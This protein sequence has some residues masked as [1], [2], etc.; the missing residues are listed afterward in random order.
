MSGKTT[1]TQTSGK[2][3][4]Q[5]SGKQTGTQTPT[6]KQA[7]TGSVQI[8]P[9]GPPL[10]GARPRNQVPGA[11]PA[12]ET[13][14]DPDRWDPSEQVTRAEIHERITFARNDWSVSTAT[15]LLDR[16]AANHRADPTRRIVITGRAEEGESGNDENLA[17][18]RMNAAYT[19][20]RSRGV[21][22]SVLVRASGGRVEPATANGS[23]RRVDIDFE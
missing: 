6:G 2:T 5:T 10:P 18:A 12:N 4:T 3:G 11:G 8:D 22:P 23:G 19:N 20:L 9:N 7:P 1:G 21:S 16:V 15:R 13:R 14:E 17:L